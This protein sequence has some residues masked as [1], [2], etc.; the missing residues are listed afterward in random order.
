MC[1]DWYIFVVL[2]CVCLDTIA[3]D[4]DVEMGELRNPW[5]AFVVLV[6]TKKRKNEFADL[7][8]VFGLRLSN[9][10]L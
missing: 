7:L 8:A 10:L 3:L 6:P 4:L 5:F 2:C 9:V 1:E